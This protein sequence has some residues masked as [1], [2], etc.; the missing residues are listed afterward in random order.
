MAIKGQPLAITYTAWDTNANVGKTGDSTSHSLYVVKDG[1]AGAATN[2]PTEPSTG[3]PG[4]YKLGLTAAEMN[5]NA[6]TVGGNSGTANVVIVPVRI[7]TDQGKFAKVLAKTGLI[8]GAS[9]VVNS[10]VSSTGHVNL[11]QWDDYYNAEARRLEWANVNG[12][13]GGGSLSTGTAIQFKAEHSLSSTLTFTKAGS[14][15]VTSGSSQAVGVEIGSSETG[16]LRA[17]Q[18]YKYDLRAISTGAGNH[19]ETLQTGRITVGDSLFA[20]AT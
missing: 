8:G 18:V 3:M 14:V 9:I 19:V 15:L 12:T 1:T 7:A 10:P 4:E 17:G 13:W 11:Q 20:S 5:A 2:S 16:P 6:I